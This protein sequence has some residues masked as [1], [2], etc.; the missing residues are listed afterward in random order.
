MDNACKRAQTKHVKKPYV[1]LTKTNSD[2][3]MS[4]N[5]LIN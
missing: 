2:F 3:A 5:N 4:N 1:A